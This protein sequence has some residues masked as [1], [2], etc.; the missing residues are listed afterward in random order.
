MINK[1]VDSN[2]AEWWQHVGFI[3]RPPEAVAGSKA[4]QV[5]AFRE[6]DHDVIVASKDTRGQELAGS[7]GPGETSIYAA[8]ADGTSQGRITIKGTGSINLYTREGNT[9]SG[10]G[11]GLFID[12]ATDTI[13]LINSQGYGIVINGDGV[14]VTAKE[15]SLSLE[16]G[17]KASLIAKGQAQVDGS[18]ILIGSNG[19]PGVNSAL[20]GPTGMA[21][22]A[23]AKV[24]IQLA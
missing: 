13:S 3:S 12:P 24:V 7:L 23:S 4:C 11:M 16:S 1:S 14:F 8:G 6:S 15:S 2:A 5:V 20:V 22:A 10:Q 9:A 21:G 18:G 17:G 19:V